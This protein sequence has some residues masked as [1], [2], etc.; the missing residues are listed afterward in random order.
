MSAF[1][2]LTGQKFGRLTVL[3]LDHKEKRTNGGTRIYWLCQCDCGNR[4]ICV[5]DS[6]KNGH[7]RS[8]GCL[9]YENRF[10]DL[11]GEKFNRWTVLGF[12]HRRGT[13]YY[14]RCKCDCGTIRAVDKTSLMSGA[15]KSCGCLKQ[16]VTTNRNFKHGMA[17]NNTYRLWKGIKDR[18]LNTNDSRYKDYGGR[19]ITMYEAWIKDFQTFYDYVSKL[20]HFG[21][22][23][24][25]L[26][27]INNNGNYE[28]DNLRWATA[29]EQ[30]RNK[31]NNIIVEYE[32]QKMTLPEASEKSGVQNNTLYG[33]IRR[34][35]TGEYL[36]RLPTNKNRK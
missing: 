12:S 35:E 11:T 34:G 21:E 6:L 7:A 28:P 8:C 3:G 31:R 14:W 16:E 27:R 22:K 19:G 1:K 32:G 29:K 30:A 2:D 26:D 33:R 9:K 23:G 36:F 4:T 20:P 5:A 13:R 24:Y 18:C 15:T 17:Y 10:E 25:S